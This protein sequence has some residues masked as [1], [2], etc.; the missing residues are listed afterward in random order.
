M[1]ILLMA[2][3]HRYFV[4]QGLR[5]NSWRGDRCREYWFCLVECLPSQE[6]PRF[7]IICTKAAL[8]YRSVRSSNKKVVISNMASRA[9]PFGKNDVEYIGYDDIRATLQKVSMR[10]QSNVSVL[11]VCG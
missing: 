3:L 6:E 4:R 7:K 1:L 9:T 8:T 2:I 10:M 11:D 5:W